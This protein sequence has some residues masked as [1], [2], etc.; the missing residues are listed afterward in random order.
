[1]E[2][3]FP[4]IFLGYDLSVEEI[5]EAVKQTF[6]EVV[7][8]FTKGCQAI[9]DLV[10]DEIKQ[11][12]ATVEVPADPEPLYSI[13]VTNRTLEWFGDRFETIE[14]NPFQVIKV[15][16]DAFVKGS[17]WVS[18]D[19]LRSACPDV[20]ALDRGMAEVFIIRPKHGQGRNRKRPNA[21]HPISKLIEKRGGAN[22]TSYR[23]KPKD[24]NRV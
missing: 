4:E 19:K 23:L 13:D 12:V 6:F 7:G 5:N 3:G 24:E 21:K 18:L 15:L 14:R 1:V 2:S 17:Q 11:A 20:R 10:E 16:Y 22:A 9:A 8:Y